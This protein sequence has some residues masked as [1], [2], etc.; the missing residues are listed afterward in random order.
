MPNTLIS[1][2]K[3]PN[4]TTYEIADQ[5]ARTLIAGGVS[6]I[7]AWDGNGMPDVTK[8]PAG[9]VITYQN[10]DYTG[11]LSTSAAQVGAFYL[12][13]ATN[14]TGAV[15]D[16][17]SEYVV[18]GTDPNKQW[19]K[20]GDTEIDFSSLGSLAWKNTVTL[21]K[22]TG[23]T[24]L[25][26]STT[27]TAADS[28]VSFTG[29]TN[30]RVLGENTTFTLANA[31]QI[32]VTP[33]MTNIKATATGTA[34]AGS[35]SANA[36]TSYSPSSDNFIKSLNA[37]Q[38]K[39]VTTSITPTDGTESVSKVTKTASKLV[40]TTIPN[41][42]GVTPK[43][44]QFSIGTGSEAETLIISGTGFSANT[45]TADVT[46]LGNA[47]TAA[48]GSVAAGGAGSAIVTSVTISDKTVAKAGSEITVA[49]GSVADSD[50]A[51]ATIATG[52]QDITAVSA[53][54]DLG[55]PTTASV[56]TGVSVTA[57]PTIS[58]ATGATSGTG[59][60]SVATGITSTSS[61]V[62]AISVGSNDRVTAI[63]GVGTATAAGQTITVDTNDRVDVAKYNDLTVTVS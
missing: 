39:L 15:L 22:G 63:T 16:Y 35:G 1:S 31:P 12:I 48:T 24:V 34:V 21:N 61:T 56:L 55:T 47:I 29:G 41:V 43:T 11:T 25:G 46:T 40:T 18:V 28:S 59:I 52:L 32:T 58:L 20:L 49:T 3:L 4:G 53:L 60:I 33:T 7:V 54:T 23:D 26:A 5:Y 17:Y 30:D 8:I 62:P 10:R 37:T 45:Y 50:T 38:K 9:V 42:T 51:G 36:V 6:F 44:L 27:F 2:I 14:Q 19:E 57:Q 13:K